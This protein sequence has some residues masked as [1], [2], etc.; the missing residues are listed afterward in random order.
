LWLAQGSHVTQ[1]EGRVMGC[2]TPE[3]N[4][5]VIGRDPDAAVLTALENA[6]H[7]DGIGCNVS[8]TLAGGY[9]HT[10]DHMAVAHAVRDLIVSV[11]E[12]HKVPHKVPEPPK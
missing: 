4:V 3:V 2:D 12:R 7:D 5:G 1:E 9:R 8:R 10:G 6:L 11:L